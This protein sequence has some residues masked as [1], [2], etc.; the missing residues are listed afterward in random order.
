MP[1]FAIADIGNLKRNLL[2][3][4]FK[5]LDELR[6]Y[7]QLPTINTGRTVTP[8]GP[9][10]PVMTDMEQLTA[11]TDENGFI[12]FQS[13]LELAP[14]AYRGQTEDWPCVPTLDRKEKIEDRLL[15]AC[16]NIAFQDILSEHPYVVITKNSTFLERPMYVD[17][18]GLA[19]HYGHA[20]DML[21]LTLNFDVAS[22][23]ATC[24]W[25]NES[26]SFIPI[27]K[28]K[29]LGVVYRVMFPLLVDQIPKRATTVGWQ[30]LPRPEQQRAVGI[31][32]RAQDDFSTWPQV[33]MIRFRQS[34]E[35]SLRIFNLFDKGEILFP[36]DVAADMA[37]EAKKLKYFTPTQIERAWKALEIF[38]PSTPSGMEQ[39]QS[40]EKSAEIYTCLELKLS[41]DKYN[42]EKDQD[43]LMAQL[44]SELSGVKYRRAF[45][46]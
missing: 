21:D 35:V 19:Q 40:I 7:L 38:D 16:Q 31:R 15:A 11:M 46:L 29:K 22:F 3:K 9:S 44:Q 10:G 1:C 20:T 43:K 41:W 24:R 37:E 4:H 12:I 5:T 17:V 34:K 28:A 27:N 39:R 32:M 30:P 26:R 23:F 25:D 14:F 8:L 33:Q 6:P 45:C 2:L 42:I 13:G 36:P 18:S